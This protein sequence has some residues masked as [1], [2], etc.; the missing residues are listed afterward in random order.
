MNT[1]EIFKCQALLYCNNKEPCRLTIEN[2]PRRV[3]SMNHFFL[4]EDLIFRTF[5]AYVKALS[6]NRDRI[7]IY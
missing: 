7:K 2:P 1:V 4:K 6:L 3:S 5:V